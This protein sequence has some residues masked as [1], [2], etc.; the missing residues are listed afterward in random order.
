MRRTFPIFNLL[1]GAILL[2]FATLAAVTLSTQYRN[3]NLMLEHEIGN[4]FDQSHALLEVVLQSSL[5][6]IEHQMAYLVQREDLTRVPGDHASGNHASEDHASGSR[7]MSVLQERLE[8]LADNGQTEWLDLLLLESAKGDICVNMGSPL[9]GMQPYCRE[10]ISQFDN[11]Q[12]PWHLVVVPHPDAAVSAAAEGELVVGMLT[13]EP[14]INAATGQIMA[15]LYGGLILSHNFDLV[16]RAGSASPAQTLAIGMAYRGQLINTSVRPDSREYRAL[17]GAA[18]HSSVAIYASEGLLA[19]SS[20]VTSIDDAGELALISVIEDSAF[21]SMHW[22]LAQQSML[23]MIVAVILAVLLTLFVLRLSIAPLNRILALLQSARLSEFDNGLIS[24]VSEYNLLGKEIA[25]LVAELH[26][27]QQKEVEHSRQLERSHQHL[28]VAAE[29]NRQ[30][31]HRLMRLQEEERKALAKELHDDLGQTLAVVSTDAYLMRNLPHADPRAVQ[32]AT[33]IEKCAKDMYSVVYNRI[34][35]LRPLA[36]NDLGVGDAIAYM[37]SINTLRQQGIVVELAIDADLPPLEDAA[38]TALYR[39]AQEGVDNIL[40]HALAYQVWIRLY[41]QVD[42]ATLVLEVEDDGIG[43]GLLPS[44]ADNGMTQATKEGY[45]L[46]SM[47]ERMHTVG[48]VFGL[49]SRSKGTCIRATVAYQADP[50]PAP[51]QRSG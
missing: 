29:Q 42:S 15:Y 21:V 22:D 36:L 24:P 18:Q 14:L 51:L 23:T 31:L 44:D 12:E 3:T 4:S 10:I 27:A 25:V 16:N 45:G 9:V 41:R 34:K 46:S 39:V 5:E 8:D 47:R 43:M 35:A 19:R 1:G 38:A 11:L 33:S 32:C 28:S 37:P 7:V 6:T 48:G 50:L 2:A 49:L 17:Q 26:H 13:R 30:L 40:H 20:P